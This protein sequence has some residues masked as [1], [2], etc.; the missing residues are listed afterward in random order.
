MG[1]SCKRCKRVAGY[2]AWW[3]EWASLV[4]PKDVIEL[5]ESRACRRTFVGDDWKDYVETV[6]TSMTVIS[7]H[8]SPNT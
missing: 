8:A 4:M 3:G 1:K 6:W 2:A 7:T 5:T